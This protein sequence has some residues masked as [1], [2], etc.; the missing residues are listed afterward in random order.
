MIGSRFYSVTTKWNFVNKLNNGDIQYTYSKKNNYFNFIHRN[1]R[2]M[3]IDKVKSL[4]F[5]R[6]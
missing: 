1:L 5:K 2:E 6:M 4:L 3:V